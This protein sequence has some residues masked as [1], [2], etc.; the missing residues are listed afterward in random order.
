MMAALAEGLAAGNRRIGAVTFLV[1]IGFFAVTAAG[2]LA[3]TDDVYAFAYRAEALPATEIGDPRL[4]LYHMAMRAL[5]LGTQAAG[6]PLS[7]LAVMRGVSAACAALCLMVVFRVLVRGY[8]L[9]PTAAL[10][11]VAGLGVSYGFWR[12]AVEADVYA[13]A[14]LLVALV[15]SLLL[16]AA[17]RRAGRWTAIV[18]AAVLAGGAVLVYQPSVL[19]LFGAFPIL[20]LDRRRLSWLIAYGLIAAAIVAA[21]Y[22]AGYLVSQKAPLTLRTMAKFLTQRS[23]EFAPPPLSLGVIGASILKSAFALGHDIVSANWLF[24]FDPAADFIRHQFSRN[25]I[26]EE[27]FTA[28]HA[29]W[30]V[31][32]PL[33]LLPA[34]AAALGMIIAGARPLPWRRLRERRI[35]VVIA[36]LMIV[37]AVIG[38]LNPVGAEPWIMVLL[39][40]V[41]VFSVLVFEPCVAAGHGRRVGVLVA[42]V[43]AHNAIGGMMIVRDPTNEFDRVKEA[44]AMANGRPADLVVVADNAGLGETLRYLGRAE[45]AIIRANHMGPVAR[46]LLTGIWTK[47]VVTIG[48]DFMGR[49]LPDLL[50]ATWKNGGRL[51]LFDDVFVNPPRS[52]PVHDLEDLQRLRRVL[53]PVYRHPTLGATLV[54]PRPLVEPRDAPL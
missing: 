20:L 46:A 13:P 44:W 35:V 52:A 54:L 25:V 3:E 7:A 38:R 34:V 26:Q 11:G 30:L 24:G 15:W 1:L 27:V 53:R 8:D 9:R 51:V 31:L 17:D 49:P 16:H 5:Y 28:S 42:L 50:A 29:G 14:L 21:G 4:M 10:A 47:D 39:P 33:V 48:R 12:Y 41:L 2:N 23:E 36:W 43:L 40:L 37:G 22:L 18:P 45:V 32:P 19:P 6:L